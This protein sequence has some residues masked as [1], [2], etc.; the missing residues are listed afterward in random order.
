MHREL[1]TTTI[2]V[3]HDFNEA[4]YLADRIAI[5]GNGQIYQIG[6]A[7]EIFNHPKSKYVEDFIGHGL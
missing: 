7:D 2:Q 1:N 5:M 4:V 3:T 6:T